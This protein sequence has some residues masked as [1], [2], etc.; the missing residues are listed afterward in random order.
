MLCVK[1]LFNKYKIS[2]IAYLL[3]LLNVAD[4]RDKNTVNEFDLKKLLISYV[5]RGFLLP[6]TPGVAAII[7]KSNKSRG[8]RLELDER[9]CVNRWPIGQQLFLFI[10]HFSCV[11]N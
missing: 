11:F 7:F 2:L 1:L 8:E 9:I 6:K 5:T 3:S 4:S 10:Y